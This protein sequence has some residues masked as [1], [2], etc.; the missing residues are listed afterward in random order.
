MNTTYPHSPERRE[1]TPG[2]VAQRLQTISAAQNALKAAVGYYFNDA[3]E[4]AGLLPGHTA[5]K[6]AENSQSELREVRLGQSRPA[7]AAPAVEASFASPGALQPAEP[8]GVPEDIPATNN[9]RQHAA[10]QT[11]MIESARQQL[12]NVY[13][14][15]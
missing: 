6:A 10:S 4:F 12:R 2:A 5:V 11:E 13:G 14:D 8:A 1:K 15:K 3:P 9:I 7:P